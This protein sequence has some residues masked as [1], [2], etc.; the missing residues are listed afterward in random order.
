MAKPSCNPLR[1]ELF[2]RI[3]DGTLRAIDTCR[4]TVPRST[5]V[6]LMLE[7]DLRDREALEARE[8]QRNVR[9]EAGDD[10]A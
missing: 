3:D 8:A 4:G 5:F 10:P 6:R 9:Q 2:L 7:R 1:N